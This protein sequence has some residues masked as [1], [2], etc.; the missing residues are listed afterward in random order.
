LS[1]GAGDR[2]PPRL[3]LV[4]DRRATA[5][6]ALGDVVA[7]A[8]EGAATFRAPD[9]RLPVAVQL[10]EKDLG[11]A[12]LGAL[13]RELRAITAAAGAALY[14]NERVDVALAC[15]AD[16]VHLPV[17]GLSPGDVRALAPRLSVATSTHSRSQ[18]EAAA[19]AGVD[20]VVFG[21]VFD[22]PSK[23]P[24]GPPVGLDG[25]ARAAGAGVPI[26]ALGGIDAERGSA[27]MDAGA[28]GVACIRAV[29]E[30]K[31]PALVVHNVLHNVIRR[32]S[33]N[34]F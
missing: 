34:R 25:L 11:G 5:G 31:S 9:G 4:T 2:P 23:R 12:A 19:R 7:A 29:S 8:L 30:A 26:V 28:V 27:C 24:F 1:S 21:P 20:F 32:I 10:R 13:A 17:A 14:V 22:T 6:R 16:G 18:V 33:S 3:Y 15:G